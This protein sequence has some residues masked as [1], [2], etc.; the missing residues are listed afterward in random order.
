MP[1]TLPPDV[2]DTDFPALSPHLLE[3][4]ENPLQTF[5]YLW[6]PLL[7]G[8]RDASH[9]YTSNGSSLVRWGLESW[10]HA[11][12]MGRPLYEKHGYITVREHDLRPDPPEGLSEAEWKK[13][14]E[15][16]FADTHNDDVEIPRG[17]V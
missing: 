9:Q 6:C 14:E 17:K 10:V 5:L 7:N 13:Y 4:W 3:A 11:T 15:E 16:F 8:G 12:D 1:I 2:Q